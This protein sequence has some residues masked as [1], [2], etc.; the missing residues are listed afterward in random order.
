MRNGPP[1][2]MG[3]EPVVEGGGLYYSSSGPAMKPA[4][5]SP[6]R[7]ADAQFALGDVAAPLRSPGA[8]AQ[9][10]RP[11][12]FRTIQVCPKDLQGIEGH[13]RSVVGPRS[14]TTHEGRREKDHDAPLFAKPQVVASAGHRL[15]AKCLGWSECARS[16]GFSGLGV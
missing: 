6:T 5:S 11:T 10:Q 15:P 1:S 14:S 7:T 12:S 2:V 16:R 13:T 8:G 4:L 9:G 3:N